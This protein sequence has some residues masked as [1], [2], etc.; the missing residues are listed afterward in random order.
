VKR[1]TEGRILHAP[2]SC[3]TRARKVDGLEAAFLKTAS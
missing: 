3:C 1:K 2:T